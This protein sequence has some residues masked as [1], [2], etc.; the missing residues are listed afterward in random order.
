VGELPRIALGRIRSEVDARLRE[1]SL[2]ELERWS[3]RVLTADALADV[4]GE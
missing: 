3:E 4:F 2:P 1:A